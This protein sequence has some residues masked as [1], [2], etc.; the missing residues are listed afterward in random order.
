M[1]WRPLTVGAG[2]GETLGTGAGD[3]DPLGAGT[4]AG[5]C[6]GR[7]AVV[8]SGFGAP[9]GAAADALAEGR[10]RGCATGWLGMALGARLA[11]G[12]GGGAEPTG[13]CWGGGAAAKYTVAEATAKTADAVPQATE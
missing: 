1:H 3:D 13:P 10:A 5:A 4:G 12:A 8:A 2:D 11:A 9:G 7:T 6:V